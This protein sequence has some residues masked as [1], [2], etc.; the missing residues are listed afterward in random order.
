MTGVARSAAM[1]VDSVFHIFDLDID[2]HD[3]EEIGSSG[4]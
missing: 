2:H 4:W 3:L 1:I